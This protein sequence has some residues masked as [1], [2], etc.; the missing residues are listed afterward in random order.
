MS[1]DLASIQSDIRDL[2]Q[3]VLTVHARV[4]GM[5]GMQPLRSIAAS[6]A[7]FAEMLP[8]YVR[9]VYLLEKAYPPAGE[10]SGPN[11]AAAAQPWS[12]GH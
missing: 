8:I 4:S 2:E 6:L 11:S 1:N 7:T 12:G 3:R 5:Q 10:R 9:F